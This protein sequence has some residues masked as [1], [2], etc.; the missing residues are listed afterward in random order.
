MSTE[1]T[2]S[3]GGGIELRVGLTGHKKIDY[4]R[5][6]L[7]DAMVSSGKL[8]TKTARRLVSRRAISSGGQVPGRVTGRLMKSI[9]EIKVRGNKGGYIKI[10]PRTFKDDHIFYP[11]VLYYGSR[12]Q[13]IK[14]RAN[15]MVQALDVER[16]AIRSRMRESLKNNLVPRY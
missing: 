10:G 14:K 2:S 4:D 9:G 8:V 15:Y 6:P 5:K 7:R 16:D 13:N 12:K 3:S 11:A 1:T